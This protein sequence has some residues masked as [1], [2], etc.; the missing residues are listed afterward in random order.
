MRMFYCWLF[1]GLY[2]KM[3]YGILVGLDFLCTFGLVLVLSKLSN[4][5]LEPVS[6]WLIAGFSKTFTGRK[7][8]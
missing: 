1:L 4:R 5:Y 6:G 2:G 7:K 3:S 8:E